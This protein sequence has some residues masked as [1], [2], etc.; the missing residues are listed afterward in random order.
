[1]ML[2]DGMKFGSQMPAPEALIKSLPTPVVIPRDYQVAAIEQ[3][4]AFWDAGTIGAIIRCPTGTGK[5]II[6][7][8][9][10]AH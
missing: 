4:F 6:G 9:I 5:T 1:M 7:S 8:L 2:F 10:W 3:A